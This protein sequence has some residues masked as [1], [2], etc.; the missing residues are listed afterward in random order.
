M[1]SEQAQSGGELQGQQEV[2]GQGSLLPCAGLEEHV[3]LIGTGF[4]LHNDVAR[5]V[6]RAVKYFLSRFQTKDI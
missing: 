5:G 2:E 4:Q 6:R 1:R 3:R